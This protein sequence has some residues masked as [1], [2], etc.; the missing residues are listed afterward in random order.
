MRNKKDFLSGKIVLITGGSKGIG[1]ET[2]KLFAR[3][4]AH[5]IITGR[6]I[7]ELE[8]TSEMINTQ[9]GSC[10]YYQG[11]VANIDDCRQ[12]VEE[13]YAKHQRLD[14]LINNAGMS[15]RG[16]FE[17][18]SLEL[19]HKVIA[20]N[21]SGAVNMTKFSLPHLIK[22]HGSVLFI[23]SLSALK[24]I[25]GVAPYSTAK[26]ALTG[27]S[28]SLRAELF[29][30]HVHVGLIFVGFTENDPDKIIYS[31]TGEQIPLKR[32]KNNDTQA[33]V[34]RNIY[35]TIYKRKSVMYLTFLGKVTQV[36]YRFFPRLSSFLLRKFAMKSEMFKH[37]ADNY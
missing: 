18:T 32:A 19:F 22:S 37:D 5:V 10:E 6:R 24:G 28:Q 16:T 35:R 7:K 13:V 27:F 25:P 20:I 8:Q 2:A 36:V 34:A 3:K 31:A 29:S 21:F 11:D 17:N 14:I 33:G 23:S 26:M 30:Q 15:M 9:Y 12:I 1:R 4:K